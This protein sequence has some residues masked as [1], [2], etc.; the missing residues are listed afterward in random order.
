MK[1]SHI[2]TREETDLV[3]ALQTRYVYTE[4]QNGKFLPRFSVFKIKMCRNAHNRQILIPGKLFCN[5][6]QF[7]KC[8]QILN[9]EEVYCD[10]SFKKS[11]VL[12]PPEIWRNYLQLQRYDRLSKFISIPLLAFYS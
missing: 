8:P 12:Y 3:N 5:F 1:M 10:N 6:F 2:E 11:Q 9:V 4:L 7:R